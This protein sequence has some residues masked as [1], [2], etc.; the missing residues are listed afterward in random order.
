MPEHEPTKPDFP[1]A[2]GLV[3]AARILLGQETLFSRPKIVVEF[4]AQVVDF[5][6]QLCYGVGADTIKPMPPKQ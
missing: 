2:K 4:H 6:G 5:L 1:A 3:A